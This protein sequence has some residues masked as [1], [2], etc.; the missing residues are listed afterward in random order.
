MQKIVIILLAVFMFTSCQEDK[1]DIEFKKIANLNLGNLSKENAKLQGTAV[2]MNLSDQEYDLKD[3]V[4]DFTIDGKD[5]GTVVTKITKKIQPNSEFSIPIQYSYETGAFLEAG[6]DP[7]S[8]YAIQLLG[9]LTLKNSKGEEITTAIKYAT[10]YE[11]LTKKEIRQD[12]KEERKKRREEKKAAKK[13]D[14]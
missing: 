2:F 5:V 4:L 12:K 8:T 11:Y 9:D 6:H 14:E 10:T 3:M 13:N 1:K 7:A